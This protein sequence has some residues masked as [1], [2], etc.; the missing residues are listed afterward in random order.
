[1]C[2]YAQVHVSG[3][4]TWGGLLGFAGRP[5]GFGKQ[6]RGG[7]RGVAAGSRTRDSVIAGCSATERHAG[8]QSL[9][10]DVTANSC[11]SAGRGS[12]QM[13]RKQWP[14]KAA[15]VSCT[16]STACVAPA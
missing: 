13:G 8:T 9:A 7:L 5:Y 11:I 1:M 14:V 16:C 10:A 2:G 6:Q 15:V 3:M 4:C 12:A